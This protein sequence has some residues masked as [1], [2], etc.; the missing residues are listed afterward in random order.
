MKSIDYLCNRW[1]RDEVWVELL[2]KFFPNC[3]V[4]STKRLLKL[5]L[6][7]FD[8]IHKLDKSNNHAIYS[9]DY[10][11]MKQETGSTKK[12]KQISIRGYYISTTPQKT[13]VINP[14]INLSWLHDDMPTEPVCKRTRSTC[15]STIVDEED[16]AINTK[17][18]KIHHPTTSSLL[19]PSP[20]PS[21]PTLSA[22][23]PPTS[24]NPHRPSPSPPLPSSQQRPS[25]SPKQNLNSIIKSEEIKTKSWE[26]LLETYWDSGEARRL[27][28]SRIKKEV[29]EKLKQLMQNRIRVS[30]A[31]TARIQVP[32]SN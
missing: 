3:E 15:Q 1:I 5:S 6:S 10:R 32:S 17:R 2:H 14:S 30:M 8:E 4:K 19:T 27:F 25:S 9:Y 24:P 26:I 28:G 23:S 7:I 13:P 16:Q 20:Y 12:R 18:Q 29:G 22:P 11:T 21:S 31:G